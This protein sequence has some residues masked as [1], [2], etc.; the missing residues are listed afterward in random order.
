MREWLEL[1]R[2]PANWIWDQFQEERQCTLWNARLFPA[3]ESESEYWKWLWYFTP[4]QRIKG[5]ELKRFEKTKR[6]NCAEIALLTD[7]RKYH[8]WRIE[9][10]F[11]RSDL[12]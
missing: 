1:S 3:C 8:S 5:D 2:I 4:G 11:N 10:N 9:L 7:L 6:F 12:E